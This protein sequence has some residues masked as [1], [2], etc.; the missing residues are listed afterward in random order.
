MSTESIITSQESNRS[1]TA[2]LTWAESNLKF[3]IC[4]LKNDF[5]DITKKPYTKKDREDAI[6]LILERQKHL[7]EILELE[8]DDEFRTW[9]ELKSNKYSLDV[10]I[11]ALLAVDP[12]R[13]ITMEFK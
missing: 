10:V 7:S 6:A 1:K 4:H 2:L 13:P 5:N 11:P 9:A 12:T 8:D 3:S